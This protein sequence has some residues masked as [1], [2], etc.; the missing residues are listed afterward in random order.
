MAPTHSTKGTLGSVA[1][2]FKLPCVDGDTYQLSDFKNSKAIVVVFMCNH[3]PYVIA[4]QDRINALAQEYSVRD[5]QFLGINSNDSVQY[6]DDNFEAMKVRAKEENY[7]FPYL[8]DESQEVAKA[9]GAVCTP[10]F[11]VYS[12]TNGVTALE[13]KGRLDDSWKDESKVT[14]QDLQMA[15]EDIL[16]GKKPDPDQKPAM[17]CSIKWKQ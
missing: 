11:F 6:P 8:W 12:V 16:D 4:V 2:D 7:T 10:E 1:P 14:R 5:V 9:Y 17:G 3:C 13:Y 15:L